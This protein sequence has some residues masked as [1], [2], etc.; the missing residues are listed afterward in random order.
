M[1]QFSYGALS[2][3]THFTARKFAALSAASAMRPPQF[4]AYAILPSV[5]EDDNQGDFNACVG[6]ATAQVVRYVLVKAGFPD[7]GQ[8][9][10]WMVWALTRQQGSNLGQNVGVDLHDALTIV[11]NVGICKLALMP[12]PGGDLA[13]LPSAAALNDAQA[14]TGIE[15]YQAADLDELLTGMGTLGVPGDL[16]IAVYDDFEHPLSDD[17]IGPISGAVLGYHNVLIRSYDDR[18]RTAVLHNQWG[19]SWA[20]QDE[21]IVTYDQINAIWSQGWV[22]THPNIPVPQSVPSSINP[23]DKIW[24]WTG[25]IAAYCLQAD[26]ATRASLARQVIAALQAWYPGAQ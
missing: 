11:R 24:K 23:T 10:P 12:D 2:P 3:V 25:D 13:A 4:D 9:S 8:L 21:V 5:L 20:P 14:Q 18:T 26:D 22:V 7:P 19:D 1:P 16:A 6:F 15:F 17:T